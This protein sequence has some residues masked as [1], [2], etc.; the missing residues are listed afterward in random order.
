MLS[1]V[2]PGEFVLSD[3][4]TARDRFLNIRYGVDVFNCM[5]H[6][7]KKIQCSE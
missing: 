4:V 5:A 6:Q 7:E 3:R 2:S 1:T